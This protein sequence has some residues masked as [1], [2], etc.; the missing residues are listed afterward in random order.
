MTMR[1]WIPTILTV[2]ALG[3]SLALYSQLPDRMAI[4]W[5]MDG[6]AN[7]WAG[8]VGGAFGVPAIMLGFTV[9][10]R[11]LPN[12]DMLTDNYDTFSSS[13]DLIAIAATT[14]CLVIHLMILAM[15]LGYAVPVL[16]IGALVI[17]AFFIAIGNVLP[18]VRTNSWIGIRT[19]WSSADD[20]NWAR[21][22]RIAGYLMVASGLLWFAL[23]AMPGV[24]ME[25]IAL[26]SI[27]LAVTASYA[28]SIFSTD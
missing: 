20:A 10:F 16:R 26:G 4:H 8:R 17:G 24:W 22:H 21:T 14:L 23:A 5:G 12:A 28:T 11:V 3:L 18:R 19:P 2:T 1:K 9:L 7:G 27:V 15:A 6:T 13:Y 25:R